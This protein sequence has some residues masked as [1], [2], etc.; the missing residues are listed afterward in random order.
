MHTTPDKILPYPSPQLLCAMHHKDHCYPVK[1]I[2]GK[3]TQCQ[4][5]FFT[6]DIINNALNRWKNMSTG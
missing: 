1:A 4:L 3:C 5:E 2:I 6:Q